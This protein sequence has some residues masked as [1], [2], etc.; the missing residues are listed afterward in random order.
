VE[1][2]QLKPGDKLLVQSGEGLWAKEQ[3]LPPAVLQVV[4]ERVAVAGGKH[5]SGRSDLREKYANM[6]TQWSENLGL[7]LGWLVGDGYLREDGVGFYFSNSKFA[8]AQTVVDSLRDW[9]G[10]GHLQATAS[11]TQCLRFNKLPAEFFAALG[12]K[13]VKAT[14]KRVPESLFAAPRE[15]VRGFLRGLFST[16]GTVERNDAKQSCSVRLA[17]SSRKL[18]EDVQLLLLNFGIFGRI[19][20]RRAA[21]RKALPDGRGGSK[22]YPIAAQYE[23]II[24][25]ESR[26]RF[27][28]VIGFALPEKQAKLEQFISTRDRGPYRQRFEVT[29][30]KVE[31]AGV[32]PVYDLTEPVSHSLIANGVVAH[33]CGEIGLYPG[34][35]CDLGAI[36]L[37][38]FVSDV[39]IDYE[40]LAQT[41]KLAVRFLDDVLTV[42]KAP[43]DD[44][45]QAIADK[46][47]IGLG[48][49]G[50]ADA[51]I[52]LGIPYD[53]E[54][55]REVAAKMFDT[56]VQAGLEASEKLAQERGVPAGVRRAGLARRNIAVFTVAP[57]GTT[58][59]IAGVSSGIEPVFAAVYDRR[60]DTQVHKVLHPLLVQLLEE[61]RALEWARHARV[62]TV[63]DGKWNLERV[64]EGIGKAHGSVQPLVERGWLPPWFACFQVAHDIAPEAHVLMQAAIQRVMDQEM[65]GNSI[66]KTINLPNHASV[67]DVLSA[68]VLAHDQGA[69]GC[70]VYRDG[71]RAFQV[72][73][74]EEGDFEAWAEQLENE[75]EFDGSRTVY[76]PA[77]AA[78]PSVRV[79]E[80]VVRSLTH[81]YAVGGRKVYVTVGWNQAG[82]VVETFINLS[83]PTPNEAVVADL[84]GRL[85]SV[86]FKHGAQVQDV[87]KHLEGH[88]DQS[89]GLAEGMG[90][91]NSMWD[92]V[93]HA[94]LS[95]QPDGKAPVAVTRAVQKGD[96]PECGGPIVRKGGCNKCEKCGYE[97]CG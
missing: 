53:S 49:M 24:G 64:I 59:M 85:L 51:L 79:R 95:T 62:P 71:S 56:I 32:A 96:C 25:G 84:V 66:S 77:Q 1:A 26:D 18:L 93:A 40:G 5:S 92:V 81:K 65:A 3:N 57:T 86:A 23:L 7:V 48:L 43:L 94:L 61:P 33:N 80:R 45:T 83:K 74:T 10:Q 55:G 47:R 41:A 30:T 12:V 50:L 87:V 2:G 13:A 38:E 91:V 82:E 67:E 9:F 36:N 15:A 54:V 88:F 73:S 37:A 4:R 42:E 90:F 27:A 60:I 35:P 11:N 22:E 8:Q 19:H 68:Y 75:I 29:V 63:K 16:D 21:S 89:G 69:K 28:E 70:T 39:G 46:R 6:P 17:S 72:L 58:S 44:I 76:P 34:E 14:E 31:P 20:H 78:T 97:T 52:K